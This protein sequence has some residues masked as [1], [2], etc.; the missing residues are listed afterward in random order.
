MPETILVISP[1]PDDESIGCGGTIALHRARGDWVAVLFLTSGEMASPDIPAEKVWQIR[2]A[3]SRRALAILS[4]ELP[5]FLR[6][7]DGRV[8][9]DVDGSAAAVAK[10]LETIQPDRIYLPHQNEDHPDHVACL[11][12]LAKAHKLIGRAEP[13]LL[14]YEVWTPVDRYD[15]VEDISEV[16]QLKMSA[17]RCY[18]SQLK[19][20]QY[21]RAV[22]GL[23]QY[24]GAMAGHCAFAEVFQSVSFPV[25]Y[26]VV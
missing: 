25:V 8:G 22:A 5:A 24:R 19:Q 12:V 14:A 23:N 4:A 20:F 3:E 17:V 2:E 6:L 26:P 11:P 18:E 13:W 10:V 9:E 21:D 15:L 16:Q 7:P 1:H